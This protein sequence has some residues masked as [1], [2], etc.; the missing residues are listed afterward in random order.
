MTCDR[1]DHRESVRPE[2]IDYNGHMNVAYYALVFDRA[3]DRLFER[4]GLGPS[5]VAAR[6]H[7]IFVVEAHVTYALEVGPGAELGVANQLLGHDDKRL[8]VFQRMVTLPQRE[9]VATNELLMLH[10]DLATRRACAFA[11]AQTS[12]LQSVAAAHA[13]WGRP[14]DSG[15][16]VV[17]ARR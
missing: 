17:L 6:R 12:I 9:P 16:G 7:S 10:V 14:E 13:A 1:I 3:G 2:W 5:Y 15:R 4:L 11:P 8:V